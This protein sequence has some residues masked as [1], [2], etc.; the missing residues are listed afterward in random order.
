MILEMAVTLQT[1]FATRSSGRRP[2]DLKNASLLTSSATVRA[3]TL[4]ELLLAITIFSI[5]LVAMSTVFY[6][7]LQLRNKTEDAIQQALPLQHTL[8][9]MK[10]DLANLVMPG[11][12]LSG[13]LQSTALG[14]G[15]TTQSSSS[16]SSSQTTEGSALTMI[17]VSGALESSP[18]F[19]TSTGTISGSG[20]WGDIQQVSYVLMQPT[21]HTAGKALVRCV[22]RNLLP[23]TSPDPPAQEWLLT[24]VQ[25]MMFYFYDGLQWQDVWDS[26]QT[27][28]T[29][30]LAIKVQIQ[31]LPEPGQRGA[32]SPVELVVPL[33]VQGRTNQTAQA[34]SSGG[35]S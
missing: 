5:V 35:T 25:E 3:F 7:A 21:N 30:P 24:G 15:Q 4:I 14:V 10:R 6:S 1:A 9:V 19:F 20:P 32:P 34:S 28:N 33:E 8:A 29:L 18:F 2:E 26:T 11:G 13:T 16:S 22:T 23:V 12:I 31:L 27:T 17:P